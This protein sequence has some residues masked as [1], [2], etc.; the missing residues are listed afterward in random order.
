MRL[1]QW[2]DFHCGH[3]SRF[4]VLAGVSSFPQ[5]V[6]ALCLHPHWAVVASIFLLYNPL[7]GWEVLLYCGLI[8]NPLMTNGI[9]QFFLVF[10]GYFVYL[11]RR[12]P[13]HT[14]C[15]F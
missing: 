4:C 13:V 12:M 6:R 9:G 15:P 5:S 14:F 7:S 10:T 3:W 11:P 2:C 1:T 8:S